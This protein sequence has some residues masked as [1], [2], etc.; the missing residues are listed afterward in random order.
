M[1]TYIHIYI[2]IRGGEEAGDRER[3]Y[4]TPL[5]LRRAT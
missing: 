1:H 4:P 2:Y 5:A 3:F